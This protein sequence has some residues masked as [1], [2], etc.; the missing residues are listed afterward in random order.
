MTT[1][2]KQ[3]ERIIYLLIGIAVPGLFAKGEDFPKHHS[4]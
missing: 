1:R 3:V 4:K 2:V